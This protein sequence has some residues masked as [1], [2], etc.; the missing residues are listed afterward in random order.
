MNINT[1]RNQNLRLNRAAVEVLAAMRRGQTLHLEF[2]APSSRTSGSL[3]P[4]A[5]VGSVRLT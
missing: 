3:S 4:K 5:A 1:M 2:R